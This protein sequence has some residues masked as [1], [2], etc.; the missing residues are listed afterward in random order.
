MSKLALSQIHVDGAQ[1]LLCSFFVIHEL[2]LGNSAGVEDPVPVEEL[3]HLNYKSKPLS[4]IE[5]RV[6]IPLLEVP[7]K[8]SAGK[9][10]PADPDPFQDAVAAKLVDDQLVLHDA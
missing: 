4:V 9:S 2:S 7:I 3:L 10:L 5:G 1:E 6:C 8:D